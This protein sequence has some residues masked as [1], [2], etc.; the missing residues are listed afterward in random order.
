TR[1]KDESINKAKEMHQGVVAEAQKQAENQASKVDW[2][3]GEIKSKWQ[4]LNDTVKGK[5]QEWD[6]MAGNWVEGLKEKISTGWA[7]LKENTAILWDNIKLTVTT[8]WT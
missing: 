4:V 6:D 2:T 1:Q 3:T 8:K 7:N 5:M